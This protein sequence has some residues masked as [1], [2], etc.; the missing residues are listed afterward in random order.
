V[1]HGSGTAAANE[2]APGAAFTPAEF[3][4]K[5]P[6]KLFTKPFIRLVSQVSAPLLVSRSIKTIINSKFAVLLL[7]FG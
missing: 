6:P 2:N 4:V 3:P 5:V 1:E 7:L